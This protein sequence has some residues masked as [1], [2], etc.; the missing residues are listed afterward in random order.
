MT[1]IRSAVHPAK[2]LRLTGGKHEKF[3]VTGSVVPCSV[4]SECVWQRFEP[5]N[6]GGGGGSQV[7]THFTVTAPATDSVGTAFNIT[8]VALDASN[9]MVVSYSGTVHLSSSD[10]QAVLAGDSTLTSGTKNFS[11]TLSS[12]GS[13]TITATDTVKATITGTSNPIQV[14]TPASGIVPTGSM[15]TARYFHTATLLNNGSVLVTGGVAAGN[16]LASAEIFDPLSGTFSVTGSMAVGRSSHTA[17]LLPNGK[18]L[19]TGGS[20]SDTAELF[21]PTSGQ[22]TVH[23]QYDYVTHGAHSY[24]AP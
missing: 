5:G 7:A 3:S 13:Q 6:P 12:V 24:A 19:V 1:S 8:V 22:F 4:H 23:R 9:S 21:D 16:G 17:T 2:R 11:A 18:V 10:A 15:A 20:S 14:S